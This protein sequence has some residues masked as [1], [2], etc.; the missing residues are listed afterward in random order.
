M[1]DVLG[2]VRFNHGDG[3]STRGGTMK[4]GMVG[5]LAAVFFLEMCGSVNASIIDFDDMDGMSG[6]FYTGQPVPW[7]YI[8]NDEYLSRGV[9]FDSRGGGIRVARAGNAMSWPNLASGTANDPQQ[10]P[11]S[12][13]N[14][15]VRASFWVDGSP[16]VVDMAGL[17]ISNFNGSGVLEAY[18]LN[19]SLLGSVSSQPSPFLFLNFPGQIHSVTFI[20]EHATFDDFTFEGLNHV[21]I[22]GAL[23]LLGS[24]LIGLF[25][26]QTKRKR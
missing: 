12:D 15:W 7:Q 26:M 3:E 9:R 20:P 2:M 16:G 13:Y 10:G 17:T 19:G 5:I 21:P 4:K 6:P 14:A 25:G 23:W 22:P 1:V 24:G 8:V 18:N 11:V